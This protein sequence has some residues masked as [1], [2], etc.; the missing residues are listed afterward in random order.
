MKYMLVPKNIYVPE[1]SDSLMNKLNE[2]L[3]KEMNLRG[4]IPSS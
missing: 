3:E 4:S 2:D 1:E